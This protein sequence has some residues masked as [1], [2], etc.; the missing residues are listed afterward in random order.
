LFSGY[1]LPALFSG[2][3]LGFVSFGRHA[4]LQ[5]LSSH[6]P[7]VLFSGH[8]RPNPTFVI[9]PV[10]LCFFG[11]ATNAFERPLALFCVLI[12]APFQPLS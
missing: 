1:R 11:K 3:R 9:R 4:P 5:A 8:E 7:L 6:E 2:Y 12:N 10:E